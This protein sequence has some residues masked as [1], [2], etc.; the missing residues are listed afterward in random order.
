MP[1]VSMKTMRHWKESMG[2]QFCDRLV[3]LRKNDPPYTGKAIAKMLG[4]EFPDRPV[5]SQ[6]VSQLGLF[7]DP[8]SRRGMGQARKYGRGIRAVNSRFGKNVKGEHLVA[9]L[10]SADFLQL[11][12]LLYRTMLG[13]DPNF[14]KKAVAVAEK[15]FQGS[16]E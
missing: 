7:L 13:V 5:S 15:M 12:G 8:S 9:E 3:A 14:V 1:N 4:S 2:E 6:Q 11:V 10:D 16:E